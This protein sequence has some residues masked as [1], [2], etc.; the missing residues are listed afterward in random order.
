[1]AL[2]RLRLSQ[3][4]VRLFM[5]QLGSG[6]LGSHGTIF[7]MNTNGGGYSVLYNFNNTTDGSAPECSLV[8]DN[9]VLYGVTESGGGTIWGTVFK[10]TLPVLDLIGVNLSGT[11]LILDAQN[12]TAGVSYVVLASASLASPLAQWTPVATNIPAASGNFTITLTN[13][14]SPAT[15]QQFYMLQAQ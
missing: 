1:M 12:G 11:N 2:I 6:G 14:V 3:S 4:S 15:P 5:E 9:N 8:V 7:C 13:A 10:F